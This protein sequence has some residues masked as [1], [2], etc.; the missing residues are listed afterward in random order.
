LKVSW[1][2]IVQPKKR[3]TIDFLLRCTLFVVG[4]LE[5]NHVQKTY[6]WKVFLKVF[7]KLHTFSFNGSF[8]GWMRKIFVRICLDELRKNNSFNFSDSG[9]LEIE[10]PDSVVLELPEAETR[11]S[12]EYL[13]HEVNSLPLNYSLVFSLY[14]LDGY[15]HQ[16]ISTEL[17]IS[18]A[19]SKVQLSR[20]R[21]T[22]QQRLESFKTSQHGKK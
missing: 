3:F 1:Q 17:G 2:N 8:E 16:E 14:V 6:S 5:I 21:K 12:L 11:P 9:T 18:V 19:A 13:L 7:G 10:A 4:I 22:L 15:S 20:A